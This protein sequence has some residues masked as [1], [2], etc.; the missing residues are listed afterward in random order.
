MSQRTLILNASFEP[1]AVVPLRR[2]VVLVLRERA[3]VIE[4][5]S[6]FMRS[7]RAAFEAPSV[8]RLLSYV[9]I[10]YK[11]RVPVSRRTVLQRD[12]HVC[13]YCR[14]VATTVDHI[15]PRAHGGKHDWRNVVA[16][17]RKC[18]SKKAD[19]SVRD[20]GFTL[21]TKPI[22]PEGTTA[23]V[24]VVGTLDAQWSP[25]LESYLGAIA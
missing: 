12:N 25:Y 7:E 24:V 2:A 19:K 6:G 20:V 1:L 23:L 5:S 15:V 16:A 4:T 14:D 13:G 22:E 9:R 18:N 3:E 17:C 8:I 10:P 11:R 21:H